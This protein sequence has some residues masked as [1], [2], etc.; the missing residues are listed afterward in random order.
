MNF[1]VSH[2]TH[3]VGHEKS[4]DF[5]DEPIAHWAGGPTIVNRAA[6]AATLLQKNVEPSDLKRGSQYTS[7]P[8]QGPYSGII[9]EFIA[10][11]LLLNAVLWHTLKVDICMPSTQ[12]GTI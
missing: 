8:S 12:T 7:V 11:S 10:A 6:V 1:A 5:I 4:F 2:R 9:A 3:R